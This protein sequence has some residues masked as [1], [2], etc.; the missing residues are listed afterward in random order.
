MDI[1]KETRISGNAKG[2]NWQ[3]NKKLICDNYSVMADIS[4]WDV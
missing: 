3:S 1:E 4:S 2:G